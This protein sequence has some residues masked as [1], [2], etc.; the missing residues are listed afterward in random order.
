MSLRLRLEALPSPL[1]LLS[2]V[3]YTVPR[4]E[5][6]LTSTCYLGP[7]WP[8]TLICIPEPA[9]AGPRSQSIYL[10][11]PTCPLSVPGRFCGNIREQEGALGACVSHGVQDLDELAVKSWPL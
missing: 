2:F 4:E 9:P 5:G 3:D 10:V 6:N 11:Y 1:L 8:F 7:L